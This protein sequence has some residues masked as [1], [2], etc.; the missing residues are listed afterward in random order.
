ME[1][2]GEIVKEVQVRVGSSS[3][4]VDSEDIRGRGALFIAC[5]TASK[6]NLKGVSK[7][8][9]IPQTPKI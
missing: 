6:Q 4:L 7:V 9:S 1:V 5:A 2:E 3:S 8:D